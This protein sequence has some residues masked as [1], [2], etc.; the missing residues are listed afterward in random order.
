MSSL[1]KKAWAIPFQ[2]QPLQ[3]WR[4][5]SGTKVEL[6]NFPNSLCPYGNCF[7][8]R[9]FLQES[10]SIQTHSWLSQ[11]NPKLE[12]DGFSHRPSQNLEFSWKKLAFC[13]K[14]LASSW[15]SLAFCWT[16]TAFYWNDLIFVGNWVGMHRAIRFFWDLLN[17]KANPMGFQCFPI[18][19]HPISSLKNCFQRGKGLKGPTKNCQIEETTRKESYRKNARIT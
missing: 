8:P 9:D 16:K 12:T 1:I 2:D 10:W 14:Q 19:I 7:F 11:K 5:S 15:K 18:Q 3:W 6:K 17:S 13:W 4:N